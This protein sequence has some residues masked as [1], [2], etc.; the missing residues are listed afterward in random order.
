MTKS[1]LKQL[2]RETINETGF[3]DMY[4][5]GSHAK[6]DAIAKNITAD[7]YRDAASTGRKKDVASTGKR[8]EATPPEWMVTFSSYGIGGTEE[9]FTVVVRG[10]NEQAAISNGKR[11]VQRH[12]EELI[13]YERDILNDLESVKAE[14]LKQ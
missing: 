12:K 9:E 14:P 5:G 7:F 4:S 8:K 1:Q 6:L 2:I 3:K 13:G 11:Y 10:A